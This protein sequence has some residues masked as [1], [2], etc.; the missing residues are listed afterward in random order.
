MIRNMVRHLEASVCT[1]GKWEQAIVQGFK[2]WRE[3][4]KG[5]AAPLLRI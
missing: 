1:T 3:V 4:K 2:I 5:R